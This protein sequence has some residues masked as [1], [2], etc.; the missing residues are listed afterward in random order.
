M[1]V[2]LRQTFLVLLMICSVYSVRA[3]AATLDD[4]SMTVAYLREGN[5]IGTGFFVL[6]KHPFL[7]TAEHVANLMNV[8]SSITV[9]GTNDTP[10]SFKIGDLVPNAKK[11]AWERHPENDVAVLRVQSTDQLRFLDKRFFSIQQFP[12][13]EATP[14]RDHAVVIMGFPHALGTTVRFSPISVEAKTASGL[15]RM[16]RFDTGVTATFFV[17]DKPGIGGFSG[18]PIFMMP[19]PI[20]RDGTFRIPGKDNPT[21]CVGLVHGTIGD[22][23][24][25]LAAIVPANA[26]VD[27]IKAAGGLEK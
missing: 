15:L 26:I 23:G 9:R 10:I 14:P 8:G 21:I 27:T 12:V 25:T 7:V 20:F 6:A 11:L 2:L 1:F 16:G 4:L 24:G 22:K 19:S 17:L 5:T 13:Q 3:A 18:G